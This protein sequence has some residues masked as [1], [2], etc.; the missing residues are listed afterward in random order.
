MSLDLSQAGVITPF[1]PGTN[2]TSQHNGVCFG[3]V[4]LCLNSDTLCTLSTCDLTLA[5][6]TY[7]PNL[8]GNAFFA[9]LFGVCGLAQIPLGIRYR[10]WGF[11]IAAI[12]GLA[13]EVI[14]YAG[15]IMMNQNPFSKTNFLI[16]LVCLTIAPAFLSAC[17]YLC[18]ARI[19][20]VYGEEISRFRP[21]IYTILFCTCDFI[22]LLLQAIG[23][24]IASTANDYNT[25]QMGINIM[26]G[27]LSFQVF[28]L[29]LFV[30]LCGDFAF[31]LWRNRQSWNVS[32]Q[33]LFESVIFRCFLWGLAT[34]TLTILIRSCFRVAELSGGF[35]GPLA[36]NQPT[37]MVLEGGMVSIASLCLTILHP[38]IG[39]RGTWRDANFNFFYAK[40]QSLG[41]ETDLEAKVPSSS[42]HQSI[43][44]PE[45]M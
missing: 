36:N 27:G 24:A 44:E 26:I 16:Y 40:K 45:K 5:H 17:I 39:F 43:V 9:A 20:V 28:S 13:G 34:A 6:F 12:F 29:T 21:R 11:V 15:R 32:H 33:Q 14:G 4:T 22:S 42:P 8:G 23:G 3:N 18:L 38:G 37:F 19:V 41:T 25:T 30:V 31:R 7:V 35:H 10:T 2:L 1:W